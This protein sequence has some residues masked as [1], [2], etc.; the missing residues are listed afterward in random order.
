LSI[1]SRNRPPFG[2][3]GQAIVYAG[4]AVTVGFRLL[5]AAGDVQDYTGREFALRV[6]GDGGTTVANVNGEETAHADGAYISCSLEDADTE[7]L[8]P[9]L[10]G[11][12]FVEYTASGRV[13]IGAGQFDIALGASA[14][15]S[16]GSPGVG[17]SGITLYT[18]RTDTNIVTVSYMGATGAQPWAAPAAWLTAT[19]YTDVPPRSV[20][21]NGGSSYVCVEAHTSG[22]F[23]TDFNAGKWLVIAAGTG[24]VG[25]V[26]WGDITGTLS[27]QTDLQT[28]LNAKQASDADLTTIAGLSPTNDDVLQRK[29]GAWTN[30]TPA[31]LKT[32]LSLVKGDVGLS[33]VDNTSDAD[34]PVSTATQTALDGKQPIDA[35][36]TAIGAIAPTNDDLIQRK[37]GAWTNRTPAQLKTDL[38]LTKADVGLSAVDNTADA[39]KPISSATQTALDAKQASDADLTAIA[40]LSPSNDDL[41]QRKSGG[42]TN[43]TPAQVK[44]DLALAKGDV[45][46][47]NADNTSDANK[48]VSTATQTA[49]DGKQTV[50]ANLTTFAGLTPGADD[51]LQYKGSAWAN[52][53]PAQAKTDLALV[54]ADVGLGS[55][56][57]TADTAKP[58]STL[59]QAALDLK[60]PLASPTFTGTVAGITKTM[61]GLGNVDNTSDANKPISSATQGALD[62]KA[63]LASPT[64]TGT[65]SGITKSMVGL[66]NVD[67]T[68]DANKPISTATQ[69]ALDLKQNADADL[70]AIAALTSA[71]DKV[72]Y[73]TGAGTWALAD[74]TAAGR[75]IAGAA[76]ASAQRT[77]LELV[78]GTDVQAYSANLGAVAG[79]TSA[80]DKLFYFTG[81]GTGAV[82]DFSSTGR[83][84]VGGANA[85]AMQSTLGLVI[86]TNVQAQSANLA[87]FAGLTLIADRL[88]YANGTGTLALAT[89]TAAGRAI[90]DDT[91]AAAQQATLGLVPG[92]NVQAYDADLAAIAALTP[93]TRQVLQYVG[94]AWTAQFPTESLIVAVGDETTAITTGTGKVTFRMPYAFKLTA[95]R[96]S[97]TTASSSGLPAFNVKRNGASIFSTTLTI[98]QS[99]KTS[100]GATT[101]AVL[102]TTDLSD[103]DEMTIDID[104]AGTG[105]AGP[106]IYFIGYRTA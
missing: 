22:V 68:S 21:T 55:V 53:T 30:R 14:A 98:N 35:D 89:L 63:P 73:A 28:A 99:A 70:T 45:G 3:D 69:T 44:T 61:V 96:A 9:G 91:D 79:V 82:T 87:A 65:V 90:L 11:W 64:F 56:D 62:L 12:E 47:G 77:A 101:P 71:A 48:P 2:E 104:T 32:D 75:T 95:V 67:N 20:V 58:V 31:Q 24:G 80:A 97:L 72:P 106:K 34:K 74:F 13:V 83:T 1:V 84:L 94:S 41:L 86:G 57:N 46:L 38:A 42:W 66:G 7:D 17:L 16:G 37:A 78:P 40:G 27:A 103:D 51:F 6:Y 59:Q 54:K 36:L 100:V 43:R 102:S 52:R 19:A 50:N 8:A 4:E 26:S 25:S 92:T 81:S 49:L 15:Q 5:D 88:P 10:R 18:L 39:N 93:T 105:A 23:A 29:S 33:A 76:N 85:A 60:A